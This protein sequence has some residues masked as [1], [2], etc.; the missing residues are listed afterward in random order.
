MAGEEIFEGHR[1]SES[2]D[3]QKVIK[4]TTFCVDPE[5]GPGGHLHDL[6]DAFVKRRR[7]Q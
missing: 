3:F 6:Y 7:S 4:I 1:Q 5:L 2:G